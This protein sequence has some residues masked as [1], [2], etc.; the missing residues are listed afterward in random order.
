VPLLTGVAE[1]EDVDFVQPVATEDVGTMTATWTDPSGLVW[2][3]TDI[4]PDLGWFTMSGP[5]G[6]GAN[7]IELVTDPLARGG[8]QVRTV[9]VSP[10]TISWPLHIYGDTHME[11]I[12]RYR[13][14]LRAFTSTTYQ[15]TPG[16]LTVSR[17]NG[18]SR[19]IYAYYKEGFEGESGQNWLSASPVINLWCPDGYWLDGQDTVISRT[20]PA[21]SNFYS[22]FYTIGSS[23][24]LGLTSINN[25]GDVDAWP[26]W[27][28]TGPMTKLTGIS[29]TL[30]VQFSVTYTLTEGQ[31]VRITTNRITVRGPGDINLA[32][33]LNWPDAVL[34]QLISGE[35]LVQFQVDGAGPTTRVDLAFR[36]RY[37]GA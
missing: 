7:P 12:T 9:R 11:F 10:R 8:E 1:P 3:L 30:G 13:Q 20:Q 29:L 22:P 4:S 16:I 24:V 34:W 5:A 15:Q 26:R 28:V 21:S 37:E 14:L 27:V 19:I 6:W 18:Q 33:A 23:Q 17:P 2:N 32:G 25:P 35:N 36:P 31:Q